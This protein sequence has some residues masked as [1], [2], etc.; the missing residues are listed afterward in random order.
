MHNSRVD[1]WAHLKGDDF[2]IIGGYESGMDAAF[3]LASCDKRCTVVSSTAFWRVTTDDPSTELAPYTAERVREACDMPVPPR[4]LA[5]LR[6]FKVQKQQAAGGDGATRNKTKGRDGGGE[7]RRGGY[8]VHARWQAPVEHL[9]GE[10]RAM[11]GSRTA[12]KPKA[13]G[14]AAEEEED[15]QQAAVQGKSD[16]GDSEEQEEHDNDGDDDDDDDDDECE[17]EEVGEEGTEITLHTPQ[18][19]LLCAGFEGSVA[20]GA[21]K[22]LFEWSEDGGSG[23][24]SGSPLLTEH[25]ESTATPGLFLAGPAVRHGELSFCFVYKFRQRF[26]IVAD[27]IARGLGYDTA[28]SV[29]ACRKMNMFLDDFNCCKGACG[30]VC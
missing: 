7:R 12:E 1:S 8:L 19:P 23:C 27:V 4:L 21:V 17:E 29:E 11:P 24:A 16:D 6:V 2:V 22:E 30:E 13:S 25:D 10:H 28:E 14:Q 18:A 5:P 20:L 26:G 9:G 3:N 15:A